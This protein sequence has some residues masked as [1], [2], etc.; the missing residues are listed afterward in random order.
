[1]IHKGVLTPPMG[2]HCCNTIC[3][4]M[5]KSVKIELT[6]VVLFRSFM[7]FCSFLLSQKHDGSCRTD[8]KKTRSKPDV[9]EVF[10]DFV[11]GDVSIIVRGSHLQ[12]IH[13]LK[14]AQ[15]SLTELSV[16][17]HTHRRYLN[18]PLTTNTNSDGSYICVHHLHTEK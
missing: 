13:L 6:E 9:I 1:M 8:F 17:K 3:D 5:R 2:N 11:G 4:F 12:S 10:K 7:F 16:Y 15:M 18:A 14:D